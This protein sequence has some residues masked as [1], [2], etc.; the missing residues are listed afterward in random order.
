MLQTLPSATGYERQ[1]QNVGTT[2]NKG[3]EWA[4]N[5]AIVDSKKF[6]LNFNFNISYNKNKIDKLEGGAHYETSSWGGT[7]VT[8][9]N[10]DFLL[11]EGGRLGELWGY[12]QQGFYTVFDPATGTGDLIYDGAKWRL[13]TEADGHVGG[14]V[15]NKSY[16]KFGG[17]L[18][19]GGAKVECDENGDPVFQRLGN[20]VPEVTGGFGFDGMWKTNF[21]NFDFNIFCNYSL[22]NKIYNATAQGASFYSGTSAGWN[23]INDYNSNNRYTWV[24]PSNGLNLGRPSTSTVEA[25]GGVEGLMSR[26]NELN[27]N[28][29]VWNPA[30]NSNMVI[31]DT[32]LEDASFLR[33]NNIT[34]GYTLPKNWV[35]KAWLE[36][37]RVYFTAYNVYCFTNYSG[38]DPE[39]D[40]SSKGNP[41]TPGIDYAAYPK[42]RSF[43]AGINVTF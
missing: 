26:L 8:K 3:I 41:M 9:G 4:L 10:G 13:A 43:V 5:A 19:P 25:Y 29:N 38:Y 16:S 35:K 1:Y 15:N 32:Y 24:D 20:T 37:V 21:G 42:S 36:S 2:S 6:N 33:I 31:L 23:I 34:V 12:K 40:T 30:A 14:D 39:V 27:A 22:G 7:K 18:Y 28:A 17:S 11:E